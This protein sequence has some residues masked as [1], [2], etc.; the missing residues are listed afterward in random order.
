MS[1]IKAFT[2]PY[3]D[4]SLQIRKKAG[5]LAWVALLMGLCAVGLGLVMFVTGAFAAGLAIVGFAGICLAILLIMRANRYLLA[6]SIFIYGLWAV[7]LAAIALDAY[8]DAYE[9]YVFG[10]LGCFLLLAGALVAT[11]SRQTTVLG[12]LVLCSIFILQFCPDLG[13]LKIGAYWHDERARGILMIQNLVTAGLMV[14]IGTVIASTLVKMQYRLLDSLEEKAAFANRNC[15]NLNSAVLE[16]QDGALQIGQT[17][18]EAAERTIDAVRMMQVKVDGMVSGMD[19]LDKALKSSGQANQKALG[20][21]EE[22][23]EA[24]SSYSREVTHA[25]SAIEEMAASIRSMAGQAER[26]REAVHGLTDLAGQ[27]EQK[28]GGLKTTIDGILESSRK[29]RE[30][31]VFIEDVAGRTN[32]LG[33][34][35]SI[36]A[37]HAG[38][39]GKGFSIVADQI[40][41]LSEEVAKSSRLISD[42]LKE[43]DAAVD[44]ARK[45]SADAQSFFHTIAEDIRGVSL[46]LEEFLSSVTEMSAGTDDLLAAIQ[47][48]SNL[49]GNT[50]RAVALSSS[51]LSS[52]SRGIDAVTGIA[53][54]LRENT[55]EMASRF[56]QMLQDAQDVQSLGSDNLRLVAGLKER[57]VRMKDEMRMDAEF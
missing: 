9:T 27:G 30:T 33:L 13:G 22:V 55:Q 54:G 41:K 53:G 25:S 56:T 48:V 2:A 43:T 3:A 51:G 11:K 38:Q 18:A 7:M 5:I 1:L 35:A 21:H 4:A 44:Q 50:E 39:A 26:K 16:A 29:V 36:E 52:S 20:G 15:H 24:L 46:M 10:T 6:S 49:T 23:K 19:D 45:E 34:N 14:T 28:I 37:A 31:S 17:L 42:T 32:L 8:Q 47:T 40:R 12:G 57:V